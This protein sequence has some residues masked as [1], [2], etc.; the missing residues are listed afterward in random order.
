VV[1]EILETVTPD[2]DLIK[3]CKKLKKLGYRLALDDFTPQESKRDL[4]GMAD[5]IKVDFRSSTPPIRQKIYEMRSNEATVFLAEKVETISEVRTAQAEGNTFF[6]GYFHSKPEII[7]EAQI[8]ANK[9]TYL[10]MFAALSK[11]SP[12]IRE[13]ERLLKLEPSLCYRLLRLA[14][15][16]LYSL[17]YRVSTIREALVAVGDNAFRRLVTIVLASKLSR[18][19]PNDDVRQALERGNF[20]ES[21]APVLH[22]NS[23]EL[24]MLGLFSMMDRMLDIP[25]KQLLGLVSLSSDLEEAL[26]G[27]PDGIGKA[28]ELCRFHERGNDSDGLLKT[29]PL[30]R[31]SALN[32]FEAILSAGKTMHALYH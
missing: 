4:V 16:A 2:A 22:E 25:M 9:F 17:R 12:D 3:A 14:N 29:N 10:Q 26:L 23:G 20:C 1:L 6:Q 27:S 21:L 19:A 24:Y 15:S 31:D 5:F 30:V 32:Y 13:V 28:L 8:S 11:P 18:S 7:A